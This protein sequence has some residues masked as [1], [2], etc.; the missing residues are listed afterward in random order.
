MQQEELFITVT[1]VYYNKKRQ[2]SLADVFLCLA[3]KEL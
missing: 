1:P 3:N 2:P